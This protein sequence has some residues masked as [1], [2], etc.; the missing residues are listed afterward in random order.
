MKSTT[1]KKLA[2]AIQAI[3]AVDQSLRDIWSNRQLLQY[4][5]CENATRVASMFA[6]AIDQATP[7]AHLHANPLLSMIFQGMATMNLS[8]AEFAFRIVDRSPEFAAAAILID[9][10]VAEVNRL[11]SIHEAEQRA[12]HDAQ[13]EL[14]AA[15]DAA[16]KA[17]VES[18]KISPKVLA[19]QAKLAS[20]A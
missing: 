8:E 7:L 16:H 3:D 11:K 14:A 17:A 2:E 19:A 15:E 18:A 9:P 20:L 13:Q 10:L 12:R 5:V 6:S 4:R 1:S